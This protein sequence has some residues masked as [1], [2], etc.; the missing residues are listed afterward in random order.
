M[1]LFSKYDI[2]GAFWVTIQLTLLSA[3]GGA[4]IWAPC[5]SP[6]ASAPSR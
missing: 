1:D 3:V 2:F 4:L 6:C 5:S